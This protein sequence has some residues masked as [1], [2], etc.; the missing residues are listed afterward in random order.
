ME[1]GLHSER[2]STMSNVSRQQ[3]F[4]QAARKLRQDFEALSPIPHAGAKG[5]E[6]ERVLRAFLNGHIPKRFAAGA[7]FIIDRADCVSRQTD[8]IVYDALNC[9]VYMPSDEAAIIPNDNVAA[10]V[11]VKSRL[12]RDRLEEAHDNIAQ[13]KKLEKFHAPEVPGFLSASETLGCL[14]AFESDL[15]LETIQKHYAELLERKQAIG[16]HLDVIAVLDRGLITWA[17]QV[18]SIDRRWRQTFLHGPGGPAS[19]GS[20]LALA[21]VNLELDTL[22]SFLRLLLA[23]LAMFRGFVHHPGFNWSATRSQGSMSL[24]YLTSITFERDPQLRADTLRRYRD[25]ARATM[26]GQPATPD[27]K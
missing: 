4:E 21:V 10:V 11:E 18:P 15:T 2:E 25:D 17:T 13:A 12:D 8:V 5:S 22:D 27:P 7:G 24:R 1:K 16:T 19:E 9:P 23:H 6:V 20:H 14:F 26:A 3:I